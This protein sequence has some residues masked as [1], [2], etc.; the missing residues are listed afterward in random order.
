MCDQPI[1]VL[2]L[3]KMKISDATKTKLAGAVTI[4][5]GLWFSAFP[6]I[7]ICSGKIEITGK[8][9]GEQ[10]VSSEQPVHF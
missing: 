8:Y 3:R 7:E 4:T 5:L 6:I 2:L 1:S 10:I 9:D